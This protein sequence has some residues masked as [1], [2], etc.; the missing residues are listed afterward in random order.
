MAKITPLF[1]VLYKAS[2]VVERKTKASEKVVSIK[3]YKKLPFSLR[4]S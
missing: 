1:H 3:T 2:I 4:Y